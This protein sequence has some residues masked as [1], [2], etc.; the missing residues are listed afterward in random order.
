MAK[1]DGLDGS[2]VAP[3]NALLPL[4][5]GTK[6]GVLNID[7]AKQISGALGIIRRRMK[8]LQNHKDTIDAELEELRIAEKTLHHLA[9]RPEGV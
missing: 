7:D 2:R 4:Y 3:R 1:K 9:T 6:E 5:V 8:W